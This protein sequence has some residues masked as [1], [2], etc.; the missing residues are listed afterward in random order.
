MPGGDVG[1]RGAQPRAANAA[2]RVLA[3]LRR[4]ELA[5]L[6]RLRA[7]AEDARGPDAALRARL[8]TH[9]ELDLAA[10]LNDLERAELEAAAEAR[11]LSTRGTVGELRARLWL[12][13][14]VSEAG[15]DTY[16]GTAFQPVPIV[17]RGKLVALGEGTGLS[18]PADAWP[19]PVPPAVGSPV[20]V[21]EPEDLDELLARADRLLGVRLGAG[22][23]DKGALGAKVAALLG[24][25]ERGHSEP[26]WR[27]E[28]EI[29]TVP[30]VRDRAGWW[31]VAEDPAVSMEQASP[32]AKLRRVLW[33]ARVADEKD[34][35]ILSWYYDERDA[36]VDDLVASCLHTR[37]KGGAG[38]RTRGWYLHKRFFTQSGFLRSLNG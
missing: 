7:R 9:Y 18:P 15:G 3:A 11:R 31:R 22:G 20:V 21:D 5:R 24:V 38:A 13:G 19:R 32:L 27:G 16:V 37:P 28:V 30:V 35:P 23:R 17:L 26:D 6:L 36:R 34:S 10:L 2:E 12:D 25:S 8:L 29:K 33:V 4:H 1:A 14:A